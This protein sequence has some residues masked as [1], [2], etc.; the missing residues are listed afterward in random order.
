LLKRIVSFS[1]SINQSPNISPNGQHLFAKAVESTTAKF[2]QTAQIQVANITGRLCFQFFK[3]AFKPAV[4]SNCYYCSKQQLSLKS[5]PPIKSIS[6][7]MSW[8]SMKNAMD[9]SYA[10]SR[11][12]A[13]LI[14]H[15]H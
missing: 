4:L 9:A 5:H 3:P 2:A 10:L 1:Q 11:S 14:S 6:C 7:T 12:L 8:P 13:L 15:V